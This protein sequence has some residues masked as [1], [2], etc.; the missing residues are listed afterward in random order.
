[1]NALRLRAAAAAVLLVCASAAGANPGDNPGLVR[2]LDAALGSCMFIQYWA[3]A[4]A[5]RAH[6]GA[7]HKA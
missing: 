2:R 5:R 1:M 6:V 4:Q 3:A 7:L